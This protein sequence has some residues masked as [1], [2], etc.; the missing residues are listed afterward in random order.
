MNALNVR[1]LLITRYRMGVLN[2]FKKSAL[3]KMLVQ[4]EISL[5]QQ[6]Q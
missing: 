4:I 5:I 6:V 2:V 1:E 3:L